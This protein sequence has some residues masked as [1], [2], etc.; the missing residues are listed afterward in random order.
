MQID[1][2]TFARMPSHLQAMFV[3]L[4]NPGSEEVVGAFPD[5]PGQQRVVDAS[6]APKRGTPVYGDYGPRPTVIPRG[7]AGSA[8]RFFYS[9]KADAADRLGSRH[10]TVKPVDLMAWL[11][12]LITPPG[13]LVLDPFAGSG[14]TGMACLREGFDAILIEREDAYVADIRRRI[15]HVSGQDAPLFSGDAA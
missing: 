14:T 13:G 1:A 10:P 6:F 7:D 2:K 8:A 12:R 3:K 4:P 9:A 5:A 15:A 11:C